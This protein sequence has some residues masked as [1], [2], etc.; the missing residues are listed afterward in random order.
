MAGNEVLYYELAEYIQKN[1]T[2]KP[3]IIAVDGAGSSGKSTFA[4]KLSCYFSAF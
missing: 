1:I 3:Y 4:D 2:D